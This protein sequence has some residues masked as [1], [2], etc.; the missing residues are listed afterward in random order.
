MQAKAEQMEA[1]VN[2]RDQALQQTEA[3]ESAQDHAQR[4]EHIRE[5]L[6]AFH[7]A[8]AA[9][10][11]ED[12]DAMGIELRPYQFTAVLIN[13]SGELIGQ[14][15][16]Y[17]GNMEPGAVV[18]ALT[19]VTREIASHTLG[20]G[21]PTDQVVLGVQLGGPVNSETGTVYYLSKDPPRTSSRPAFKWENLPLGPRLRQE[22]GLPTVVLN[23]ALAFAEREQWYGVGQQTGD[24]VV[25][26]IREG[27]DGAIVSNG[28][29]FKGPVEIG[30]FITSSDPLRQS[31]AEI[32]GALESSGG[33]S[34]IAAMAGEATGRYIND[35]ETAIDVANEDGPG[36]NAV[37]AF[38]AAGIAAAT[39]LAYL[40]AF[41]GPSMSCS[42][43][44]SI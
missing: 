15:T 29:P 33:G 16:D 5:G 31:D 17:L 40:V 6:T 8:E 19:A 39:G 30:Q 10:Q 35:L 11:P 26:L 42:T 18:S 44:Q 38:K 9:P 27:V 4:A 28:Q 41:A 3:A 34:A 32:S 37:V 14:M 2:A 21:S 24:F 36:R 20:P 23:D 12:C 7:A 1:L 25:M 22:T 43:P 13:G